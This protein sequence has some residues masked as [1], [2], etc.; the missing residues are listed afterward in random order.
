VLR[1]A[2]TLV[3]LLVVI[4][5]IGILIGLLLPAINAARESGRRAACA[6][7]IK[8]LSLSC[9][10]YLNAEGRFPSG[11]TVPK[12]EKP[13]STWKF[14]P[15]WVISILP[16]MEFNSL[17]KQFD[18]TKNISD[19][20]SP[21]NIQARANTVP[22]MLCPSD[23]LNSKPYI[24]GSARH[25]QGMD[26]NPWARGNYAANSAIAYLNCPGRGPNGND[27]QFELGANSPGWRAAWLRGVMGCNVGATPQQI[28]DGLAFTCLI[29]EL[30]AGI[31][32]FDHRGTWALGE[33]G[34]STLWG[35]GACG[36]GG[37]NSRTVQGGDDIYEGTEVYAAIGDMDSQDANTMGVWNNT[38]YSWQA[39]VKSLHPAGANIAMCDG[40]VHF[41][42]E[43]IPYNV[44]GGCGGPILRTDMQIWEFLMAAGDGQLFDA[45]PWQ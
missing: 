1:K 38:G 14:G 32:S 36:D 17:Y 10:S 22:T 13:E 44:T 28:P 23:Y 3:E 34:G 39:G 5:I 33:C 20:T 24:P 9:M 11:M 31:A 15:N 18:L 21:Q 43:N 45:S 37:V 26:L 2:F 29:G 30:R 25:A 35:F 4:A 41:I 42:N 19:P 6:N 27:T 7:N 8:Q 40:S 16:F 12:G